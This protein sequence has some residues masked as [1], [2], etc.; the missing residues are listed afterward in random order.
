[1][2]ISKIRKAFLDRK[3]I[4]LIDDKR[5][6]EADLIFP[7]ELVNTYIINTMIENKGMLCVAMDEYVLF[8]RGFFKLPSRNSE[9][10]FFVPVDHLDAGTGISASDRAKTI[11]ALA[12]G[13]NINAFR[14]PGH[15]HLLGSI[16]LNKRQGHTELS[17]EIME[18]CGFSRSA[19]IIE[20]L[21][22]HGNSHNID[23]AKQR[24][25]ENGFPIVTRDQVIQEYTKNKQLVKVVSIASLPTKF[26]TFQIVSFE[27]NY[28]F[29]EHTAIIYGDISKE[30]VPVRIHSECLTGDALGSL[31][32]DCGSQLQNAMRYIKSQGRG[33]VL[34][35]RQEGRGIGLHNKIK[36]YH[37]QDNGMDTVDANIALGFPEDMRDY[38]VAA[39]MLRAL[40]V[41]KIILLSNNPDKLRQLKHYQIIVDET[42]NIFGEI[43]PYNHFY[44]K[45][46]MERM[47]HTFEEV[48]KK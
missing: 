24:A 11:R 48:L 22:K 4:V 44:L 32:C 12:K 17:L 18:L 38:G 23:F 15:I 14:Y 28:D 9:T 35:L 30:P 47:G 27:N 16:G 31:R 21:D 43:T 46:K 8:E 42:R 7:A 29:L 1:M 6:M 25:K 2:E 19:V 36:A 13:E 41:K 3:P 10:N 34:Y 37:L 40:G 39:Q 45:T 33:I 20:I 5:E 26:G